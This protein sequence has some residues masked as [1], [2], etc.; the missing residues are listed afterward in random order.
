MPKDL[1]SLCHRVFSVIRRH[2][3]YKL[4]AGRLVPP[5]LPITLPFV[6][7]RDSPDASGT[8]GISMVTGRISA[9]A[10]QNQLVI[11]GVMAYGVPFPRHRYAVRKSEYPAGDP[12]E[13][14]SGGGLSHQRTALRRR[15]QNLRQPSSLLASA[16]AGMVNTTRVTEVR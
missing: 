9:E 14:I 6:Y 2:C 8:A 11:H 3:V 16:G 12:P 10:S 4:P 13:S 7:L 1:I 15:Q 5:T